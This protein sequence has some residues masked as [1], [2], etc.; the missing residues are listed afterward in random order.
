VNP[1]D[2]D[3]LNNA[4]G[5]SKQTNRIL[6]GA[7]RE[8]EDQLKKIKESQEAGRKN[9]RAIMESIKQLEKIISCEKGIDDVGGQKSSRWMTE[10]RVERF[11]VVCESCGWEAP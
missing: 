11:L 9:I 8:H 2:K 1:A 10:R 3:L 7:I 4:A 6:L 5:N